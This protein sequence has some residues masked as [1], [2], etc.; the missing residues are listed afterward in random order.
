MKLVAN[1]SV[2]SAWRD[3]GDKSPVPTAERKTQTTMWTTKVIIIYGLI[4]SYF[5]RPCSNLPP[6]GRRAIQA[7]AVKCDYAD[8]QCEWNGT[9]GTLEAHVAK[10][11]FTIIPCPK[12]CRYFDN[13]VNNFMRKDMAEHLR[14]GCANRDY[15]CEYCGHE[16]QYTTII[17]SHD[18]VCMEKIV[19]CSVE[20]CKKTMR[21][22]NLDHHIATECEYTVIPCEYKS[23]GCDVNLKRQDMVAHVE[24]DR[25]HLNVALQRI[26]KLQNQVSTLENDFKS[27][28]DT[29]ESQLL[30]AQDSITNLTSNLTSAMSSIAQVEEKCR[31]LRQNEAFTFKVTEYQSKVD[32]NEAFSSLPFYAYPNGY[33]ISIKVCVNGYGQAEGTHVSVYVSILEGKYDAELNWPVLGNVTFRLLNQLKDEGHHEMVLGFNSSHDALVGSEWGFS[34]FIPHSELDFDSEKETRYLM[35]NT[36]YFSVS[37]TDIPDKKAWLECTAK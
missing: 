14:D 28:T 19:P 8:L 33:R 10:C 1:S 12:K 37:I 35:D 36:L 7:L 22:Q 25:Y 27:K 20:H 26:A 13:N 3:M 31:T 5:L 21:R 11:K 17:Q 24:D 23:V 32:S 34:K 6:L 2:R 16:G 30:S 15:K 29:L 9:V 4:C 18:K